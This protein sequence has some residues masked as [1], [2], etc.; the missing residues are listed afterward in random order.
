MMECDRDSE[1]YFQYN[2]GTAKFS[3][4]AVSGASMEED[5]LHQLQFPALSS[6]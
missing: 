6:L 1:D 2:N 4:F 5:H 3:V